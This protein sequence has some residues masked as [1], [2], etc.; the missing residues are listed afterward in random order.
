MG[1][2]A[3]IKMNVLPKLIFLFQTIPMFLKQ[4]LLQ[5]FNRK[6]MKF[7]WQGKNEDQSEGITRL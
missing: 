7:V 1:R 4:T 2:I 3:V 6:R 5:D